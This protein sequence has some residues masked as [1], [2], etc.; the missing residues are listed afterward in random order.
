MKNIVS[1]I[2][3]AVC[4][5]AGS[6]GGFFLKSGAGASSTAGDGLASSDKKH[7]DKGHDADK[8][9]DKKAEKKGKHGKSDYAS[10]GK[11]EYYKFT[12]EFIVPIMKDERVE[13]LVIININLETEPGVSQSLFTMEP[14]LRDN[15]MTTLIDLSN[16]GH[17]LERMTSAENYETIRSMIKKNLTSVVSTGIENVLIVDLAKQDV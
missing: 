11:A 16:D 7:D 12:R 6:A 3:L 8:G 15:I 4:I 1:I 9:H 14:K 10:S 2:T 17:T 5:G 13:S